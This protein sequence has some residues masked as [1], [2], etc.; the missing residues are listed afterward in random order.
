ML[1]I[2]AHCHEIV[3]LNYTTN[4]F[5]STVYLYAGL[6]RSL[7]IKLARLEPRLNG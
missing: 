6:N 5:E 1:E 4:Q 3:K 2:L 7:A